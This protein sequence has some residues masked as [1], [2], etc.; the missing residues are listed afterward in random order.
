MKLT[1]HL[2]GDKAGLDK[3]VADLYNPASPNFHKWLTDADLKRYAPTD[4]QVATVRQ[5][6]EAQ[7]LTVLSV[8]ANNLSLRVSGPASHVEA[9]FNTELHQFSKNGTTFRA[10]TLPARLNG[11]GGQLVSSVAGLESHTVK[12]LFKRATDLKT[13]KPYPGVPLGDAGI[14]NTAN[15]TLTDNALQTPTSFYLQTP[16]ADLPLALYYG[17]SYAY[18]YTLGDKPTYVGFTPAQLQAAYGLPAV[19]KQGLTGKGQTIVLLEAFGYPEAMSDANAFSAYYGLPALTDDNFSVVYPEGP[20]TSSTAATLLGWDSEIALDV[21]WAHAIAPDA[22]IVVVATNGQDNEDFQYSMQY[23]VDHK[24]G[25]AVSDSWETDIELISGPLEKQSY[26]DV[27]EIAAAQGVSF[28]FSTGDSGD[29]G[30]GSPLGAAGVP[31]SSPHA[32]AVGGTALLNNINGNGDFLPVGWGDAESLI[33]ASGPFDPPFP[34]GLLGGAGGGESTYFAKPSWQAG[35]PGTGRQTP[36][37]SAL[38]DPFTGVQIVV[39]NLGVPILLPGVGGTSL[40]SPIFTAFWALA[41]QKA[42][43]ALGQAAPLIASLPTGGIQDVLPLQSPTS[44]IGAIL[45]ATALTIYQ[46]KDIF[47]YEGIE[48]LNLVGKA[49]GFTSAIYNQSL[50]PSIPYYYDLAF[51][52]DGSLTVS[53]GWDNVTGYGTPYGMTFI[54]AVTK[55]ASLIK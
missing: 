46:P 9:A 10:N 29:N 49:T 54:N 8:G 32:T 53:P 26:E 14:V 31:S 7:G 12:P 22:K 30:T 17:N 18:Q 39:T 25:S 44:P 33:D 2:A 16:G 3:A 27:L 51:G 42:G 21:D 37:V 13:G 38:A 34:G 19:Y 24:L 47:Q 23:I 1:V 4:A 43:G 50:L 35:L 45:D 36:D 15:F 48:A 41:Q 6:L 28:Q 11:P 20:P 5:G 52:L 40:A 55:A